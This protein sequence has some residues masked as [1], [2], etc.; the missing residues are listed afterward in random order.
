MIGYVEAPI[1]WALVRGMARRAGVD[2]PAAVFEGWLSRA[3]LARMVT[4][5]QSAGCAKGCMDVLAKPECAKT[6]P[7]PFCAIKSDLEALAPDPDESVS[8]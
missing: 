6:A 3:E 2:V 8:R 1:T 7:P 4:R 5:C